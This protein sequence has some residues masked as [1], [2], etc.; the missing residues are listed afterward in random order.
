[1]LT[2]MTVICEQGSLRYARSK[3]R[4]IANAFA[5]QAPDKA[6]FGAAEDCASDLFE[7]DEVLLL[8]VDVAGI[9]A[10]ALDMQATSR[11]RIDAIRKLRQ[12]ADDDE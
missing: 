6:T 1:M 5:A 8:G 12:A 4:D 7:E 10:K 11:K 3:L 2:T 9:F